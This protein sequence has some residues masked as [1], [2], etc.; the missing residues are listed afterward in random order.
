[1]RQSLGWTL[2]ALVLCASLGFCAGEVRAQETFRFGKN[3]LQHER[4]TWA[5]VET[6]RVRVYYPEGSYALADFTLVAAED[7]L[8][9]LE[10]LFGYRPGDDDEPGHP[11][12]FAILA[13]PG[14]RA[15][16]VTNAVDLPDYADGIGGVT[17]LYKNRIALP[18]G[19]DYRD[20]RRVLHHE[21]VHAVLNDMLYGGTLQSIL[22][23]DVRL[24]LPHWF[25]E[26]LAEYAA[27]GWST[28]ADAWVRDAVLTGTL[29]PIDRL[30]GFASYQAGQSVWD[31]VA[32]QYGEPKI[33][34]ILLRLRASQS[35]EGSFQ[36]SLGISLD[37]L[38]ERWRQAL[39]EQHYAELAA[40]D[41][42]AALARPLATARD[43]AYH[44]SPALSPR[45]DRLA[46]VTT[47]DGLFDI[48]VLDVNEPEA[49]ATLVEG[50]TTVT[51]EGLRVLTPGLSWGPRGE[52]LAVA[53]TSGP[54]EAVA[55]VDVRTGSADLRR[56]PGIEQVLAVAW[57]PT[58][59]VLALSATA[60]G[61]AQSDIFLLGLETG[62]LRNLTRDAFS[63][64]EPAWAPDGRALVFHSDRAERTEL[65]TYA[66]GEFADTT[67]FR[68]SAHDYAQHDLYLLPLTLLD[69]APESAHA[70]PSAI[71]LTDTPHDDRSPRFTEDARHLL[72]RA[73]P[74]GVFDVYGL[75]LDSL[76]ADSLHAASGGLDWARAAPG[77]VRALTDLAVG[78]D[79]LAASARAS[80]V[81]VTALREGVP[82]LYLLRDPL[83]R[84]LESPPA[85]TVWQ[86]RRD[87]LRLASLLADTA[88]VAPS[89]A[90]A[91]PER[92][93]SN[94][95]LRDATDGVAFARPPR[96]PGS[97]S[98]D[99]PL[100]A[101]L[102]ASAPPDSLLERFGSSDRAD[103]DT[104]RYGGVRVDFSDIAFDPAPPD[105]ADLTLSLRD[106]ARPVPRRYKLDFSP[107]FVYGTAGYDPLYGAQSVTQ[108]VFSDVLG[109]HRIYVA[110]NLLI[111]LRNSDYQLAYSYLP[112][113][114]DWRIS[115]FHLSRLLPD[116]E[117]FTY[118]R[119]RQV[120]TNL[121]VSYPLDKFRR[122]DLDLGLLSISQADVA[123]PS[124]PALR[125]VLLYPGVTFTRDT[126][127]PGWRAP[128]EG[129]RLA[130]RLSGSAF[131]FGETPVRFASLQADARRYV[132]LGS[133]LRTLALRLSAGTSIGPE[134]QLFYTSGV[135]NWIAPRFDDIE[136]FPVS[137]LT[138]FAFATPLTPLRGFDL[139]A[140]RGHHFGLAN[141]EVRLPLA[142]AL[143][144]LPI[145]ALQLTGF[146]DAALV[147]GAERAGGGRDALTLTRDAEL[148]AS[149]PADPDAVPEF[150][151]VLDDLLVG[152]GGGL[153]AIVLGFPVRA[154]W[155]WPF[156]GRRFG[157]RRFYLS[158]A[159][160]F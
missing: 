15:F 49:R 131:G 99:A 154:D 14:P 155:A 117:R 89:L 10:R 95:F 53:V 50:Q 70:A 141:A 21:L 51:F 160:D 77:E 66:P 116:Y 86:H 33:A 100:L 47:R 37:A 120:G 78:L 144:S 60:E 12:R 108:M 133:P 152:A 124:V 55:L 23:N 127:V 61:G 30:G 63:D 123:D 159:A 40:R 69:A 79:G 113:R 139:N 48:V 73:D 74:N 71:R 87:G 148:P 111:D 157:E 122:I 72:F 41:D 147:W 98:L 126:S 114:A 84:R 52:R 102:F 134:Q 13:Y 150:E 67:A 101:D 146:S 18:F 110:T 119:Y 138:D 24:R 109:N 145:Y 27:E 75:A 91:S 151:R 29:P 136:G 118:Y 2:A 81:V 4:A 93:R 39:R 17:E 45:G 106:L 90:V 125:R 9:H 158:I 7:A 128:S 42:L 80:R 82:S 115:T 16:A 132:R 32:A 22:Q 129:T 104:T 103:A 156:D 3:R 62:T 5:F 112:R 6:A 43:G 121:A 64:H 31:Y 46:Y 54:S 143:A 137:G 11:E 20:Y 107:D 135:Q 19:G 97:R 36:R 35:V 76:G 28:D 26:G 68:M 83:A 92:R 94:A 58:A 149:D 140:R 34:E 153:R 65:A 85:P 44:G 88:R 105:T 142:E 57:H 130:V 25:S 8:A 96:A 38:S 56:L 59:D 1:M